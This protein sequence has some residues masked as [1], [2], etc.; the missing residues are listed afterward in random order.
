MAQAMSQRTVGETV[1]T[2]SRYKRG[3]DIECC[4]TLLKR[5]KKDQALLRTFSRSLLLDD[6][7]GAFRRDV[8]ECILKDESVMDKVVCPL[9]TAQALSE[10]L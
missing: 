5:V 10:H 7:R 2:L 6:N 1:R 3:L 8:M 4:E 9:I